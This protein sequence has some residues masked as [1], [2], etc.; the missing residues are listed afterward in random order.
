M[1]VPLGRIA[2]A[3]FLLAV[4]GLAPVAGWGGWATLLLLGGLALGVCL[5]TAWRLRGEGASPALRDPAVFVLLAH[6]PLWAFSYFAL[7]ANH[8]VDA[9]NHIEYIRSAVFD[10]DLDVRNDDAILGGAQGENPE[11]DPTQI[12]M[13]GI[14]AAARI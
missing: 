4:R 7:G 1:R 11:P 8:G 2:A 13:H 9:I 14:G 3:F 5:T 6:F 12:N 10:H